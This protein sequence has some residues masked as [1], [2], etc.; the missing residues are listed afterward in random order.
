MTADCYGCELMR[1][2]KALRVDEQRQLRI[3]GKLPIVNSVPC[4]YNRYMHKQ[5]NINRE[6]HLA[7]KAAAFLQ[8]D[9][10]VCRRAFYR[11]PE[12]RIREVVRWVLSHRNLAEHDREH[13][14]EGWARRHHAGLYGELRQ[15]GDLEHGGEIAARAALG[16]DAVA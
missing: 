16:H 4:L 12:H 15:G 6:W 7:D 10:D 1:L 5:G 11:E 14:I 8:V 2:Y 3:V 13:M 9:R